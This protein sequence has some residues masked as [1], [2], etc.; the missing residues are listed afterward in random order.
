MFKVRK[1]TRKNPAHKYS[2]AGKYTVSLTVKNA[3]G[4]S[5]KTMSGYV[6]AK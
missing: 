2:K 5:N 1:T 4:S 3:N 6:V